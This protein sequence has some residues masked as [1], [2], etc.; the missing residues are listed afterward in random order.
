MQGHLLN[1]LASGMKP[2]LAPI[3]IKSFLTWCKANQEDPGSLW[4]CRAC[5]ALGQDYSLAAPPE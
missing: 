2:D 1:F 5:P 4:I 3:R